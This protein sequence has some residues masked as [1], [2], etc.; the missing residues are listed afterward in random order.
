M[1]TL[2][3]DSFFL[4]TSDDCVFDYVDDCTFDK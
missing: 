3:P 1:Y 2:D 4:S